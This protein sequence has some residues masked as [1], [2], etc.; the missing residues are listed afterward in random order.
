MIAD[1]TFQGADIFFPDPWR[2]K[3]HHKRRS[4]QAPFVFLLVSKLKP[5]GCLHVTTHW[6]EYAQHIL[7]V[8]NAEPTLTNIADGFA[9]RTAYRP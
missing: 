6:E 2:K 4:I 5:G 8:L 1:Q 3:R 7:S 9:P